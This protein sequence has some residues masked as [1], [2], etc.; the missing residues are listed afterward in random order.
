MLIILRYK[1]RQVIESTPGIQR[2]PEEKQ[3]TD[4]LGLVGKRPL[5]A[6]RPLSPVRSQSSRP[7]SGI[8]TNRIHKDINNSYK[9][10]QG[11]NIYIS[12]DDY[13]HYNY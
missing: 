11:T 8:L 7:P 2:W 9:Y 3:K 1:T 6:A 13:Y 10:L 4:D 5:S 12:N